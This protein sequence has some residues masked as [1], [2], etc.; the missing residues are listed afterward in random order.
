MTNYVLTCGDCRSPFETN[1]M[2]ARAC[3]RCSPT[4]ANPKD[5]VGSKKVSMSHVPASVMLEVSLAMQEGAGKYG[6]FNWADKPIRVRAYYDALMRH[7]AAWIEGEDTDP[8]S[9]LPHVVKA[10][11][12]LVVLRDA[13]RRGKVIDD[14]PPASPPFMAEMNEH[15]ARL[16]QG[17]SA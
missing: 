11:A 15:A 10:L 16:S 6:S 9:G 14:R 8:D 2:L 13:Q 17:P 5:A 7:M 1:N 12:T 3:P 4:V